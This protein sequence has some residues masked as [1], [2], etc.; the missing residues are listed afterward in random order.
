VF[1]EVLPH[2]PV[3][4][5]EVRFILGATPMLPLGAGPAAV[6]LAGGLLIQGLFFAPTDLPMYF[7]NVS[8]LLFPMFAIDARAH[9]WIPSDMPSVDLRHADVLGLSV[10]YQGG[11]VAWV[12]FWG[13]YGR[14]FGAENLAAIASFGVASMAVVLIEPLAD[15]AALAL[16]KAGR[17]L[18]DAGLFTR[19]L[20]HPA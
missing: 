17:R 18:A 10:A 16:A 20:H 19:R 3:G 11:V 2:F 5:S 9:R 1:F 7:V 4:V 15:L 14:G 13:L 6:G 8:T 12:A